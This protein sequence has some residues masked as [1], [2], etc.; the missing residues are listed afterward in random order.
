MQEE[1]FTDI[2]PAAVRHALLTESYSAGE[3]AQQIG[4]SERTFHRYLKAANTIFRA[5]LDRERRAVGQQ[6][7]EVASV[8][9]C[10]IAQSLGY[11]DSSSF[12]RAFRR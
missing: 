5:E 12:N 3:I 7:L 11:T 4:L 1:S 10:E 9:V 8:S 2:L 6:L